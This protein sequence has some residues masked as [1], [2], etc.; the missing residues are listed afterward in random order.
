MPMMFRPVGESEW[1][2]GQTANVSRTGVLF[3]TQTTMKPHTA[4]EMKLV[5]PAE[6]VG[7]AAG[8][9]VCRGEV[10]R[11]ESS[12]PLQEPQSALAATIGS[13]RMLPGE[14]Q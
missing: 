1:Q 10:I 3:T 11:A 12:S 5:F 9:V 8:Q 2:Q 13:F 4:L 7:Q 14:G 6:I